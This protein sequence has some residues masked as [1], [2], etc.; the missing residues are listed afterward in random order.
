MGTQNIIKSDTYQ[1]VVG[2]TGS[3]E[4]QN[5]GP[6]SI[7]IISA[8]ALPADGTT[9][10]RVLE[11]NSISCPNVGDNLYARSVIGNAVLSWIE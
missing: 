11:P 7:H 10:D 8:A 4:V 6:H 2:A 5:Q 1:L 9:A 3:I